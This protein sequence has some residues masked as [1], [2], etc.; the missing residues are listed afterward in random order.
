MEADIYLRSLQSSGSMNQPR[1]NESPEVNLEFDRLAELGRIEHDLK[2]PSKIKLCLSFPRAPLTLL[3]YQTTIN[4]IDCRSHPV[5]P[6]R[7]PPLSSGLPPTLP[8]PAV[9]VPTPNSLRYHTL[10]LQNYLLRRSLPATITHGPSW[11]IQPFHQW[12]LA[13]QTLLPPPLHQQHLQVPRG[14]I[15]ILQPLFPEVI[16]GVLHHL[17]TLHL[18]LPLLRQKCHVTVGM[19]NGLEEG[20]GFLL[21]SIYDCRR[22]T[23]R[24]FCI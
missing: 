23:L 15:I 9:W 24:I 21:H 19:N 10:K 14:I 3:S 5:G 12:T 6:P 22:K 16:S 13:V 20:Q 18:N 11:V 2:Y 7:P 17:G 4:N 8:A 1:K